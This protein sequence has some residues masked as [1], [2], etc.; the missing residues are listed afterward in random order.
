M[1]M[2]RQDVE[3]AHELCERREQLWKTAETIRKAKVLAVCESKQ[4][5]WHDRPI[6]FSFTHL[7]D[8]LRNLIQREAAEQIAAINRELKELG[9]ESEELGHSED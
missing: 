9:V 6:L 7:T 2:T 4:R 5:S 1:S 3:R 8:D